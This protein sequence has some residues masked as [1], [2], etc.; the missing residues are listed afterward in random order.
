MA[1]ALA[2]PAPIERPTVTIGVQLPLT[3]ER[4]PVGRIMKNAVE[5]AIERVGNEAG[6]V[7]VAVFEDDHGQEAAAVEAVR[8]LVVDRKAAAIVGE[9]F[10]PFVLASRPLVEQNKVPYLTGGTSPRTTE[11]SRWIFR[12]GA[13]DAL[14]AQLVARHLVETLGFKNIAV[15][16]S[17]T[18]IHNARG[19][20]L[21][22]VLAEKYRIVPSLHATWKGD[23]RDFKQQLGAVEAAG[24]QAII[25]LGETGE[26]AS[27]LKQAKD[28]GIHAPIFAHR[29]FGARAALRDAGA[30]AEGLRIFTEYLPAEPDRQE[31]AKAYEARYGAETNVI[32]AQYFD[33]VLLLAQAAKDGGPTRE[34]IAAGLERVTAFHGVMADYTFK[35]GNGVHR[36]L[37][38][39]VRDGGLT[40]ETVRE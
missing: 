21:I 40:L 9:L 8:R 3:G 39:R 34:G 15:L 33:A 30:A 4:A 19:E 32:A 17:R 31:W 5:M 26:A 11:G 36:F 10:S 6:P 1:A 24:A 28:L 18:G 22:K 7:L 38:A 29:D 2:A 25:A 27:F 13:S 12:V 23:D 35:G 16:H 14:L 20:L 37:V